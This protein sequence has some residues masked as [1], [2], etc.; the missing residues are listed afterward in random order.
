MIVSLPRSK[1]FDKSPAD[2]RPNGQIVCILNAETLKTP[3][4]NECKALLRELERQE[5]YDI[6]IVQNAFSD[7]KHP[8]SLEVALIYVRKKAA[9]DSCITFEHFKRKTVRI[10]E[11]DS[12]DDFVAR[13]GWIPV[14]A[15]LQQGTFPFADKQG[16]IEVSV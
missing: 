16:V 1:A 8:T 10:H 2:L 6:Q 7:A 3:C 13:Y 11:K 9:T 5:A 4:T 14:C 15:S 12:L